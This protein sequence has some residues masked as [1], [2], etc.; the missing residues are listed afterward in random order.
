MS[1]ITSG[2]GIFSG[3]NRD[4]LI[5]QLLALDARPKAIFQRRIIQLQSISA[6]YLD[7]N[8]RLSSLRTAA[9]AFNVNK[10]FSA[11]TASSSNPDVATATA[12][13]NAAVGSYPFQFDR[14]V[15]TQ[16]V[17]STGF[18]DAT[19][20][21]AGLTSLTFAPTQARL[22]RD[23][24][25]STLNGG[26]GIVRGRIQITDTTGATATVDLSRAVSVS[27]VINTINSASGVN[28]RAR[29][30]GDRFVVTDQ[31]GGAGA[32][33]IGEVQG[34]STAASLGLLGSSP[35]GSGATIT[36]NQV[37]RVGAATTLSAL[38][39][40]LGVAISTAGGT[41]TPD[42][43][44]RTRDGQVFEIDLGELFDPPPP[45]A[46]PGSPNVRR[47]SA[48]TDLEGVMRRI[49][50]QTSTDQ[51]PDGAVS[52]SI[53]PGGVGLRLVDLTTPNGSDDFV[54]ENIDGRSTATDLGIAGTAS[55]NTIDGRRLVASMNST[56]LR[57][58][59]G[60]QGFSA[61]VLKVTLRNG[62]N[63]D[64]TL[65]GVQ[66]MS[67]L[68][69]AFN[70]QA[71]GQAR[72]DLDASGTRLVLSDLTGGTGTLSI[73]GDAA[74]PLGL[75]VSADAD[76][77]TSDR[78]RLQF[79]GESTRLET[80][81]Q[82][83]GVGTGRLEFSNAQG[84]RSTVN[85]GASVLTVGDLIGEI[86]R[87]AQ[88]VR[89][90]INDAGDGILLEEIVNPGDDPGGAAISVRDLSGSIARTLN[91][92]TTAPGTGSANTINGSLVRTVTFNS[93]DSLQ[94]VVNTLNNAGLPVS[95]AVINDGGAS[96]RPFR[97]SMTSRTSGLAGAFSLDAT[98]QP[99][100]FNTLTQAQDARVFFGAGDPANAVLLTSS[101]NTVTDA[102]SGLT[103]TAK[104]ASA[105]PV[106]ITVSRDNEAVTRGVQA[107][108]D[109]FNQLISRIDTLTS[110]DAQSQ[111][112][113]T[114]LGDS[115]AL[116]LRSQLFQ[117]VTSPPTGVD[118]RFQSLTQ[119]GITVGRNGQLSLDATRLASAIQEDAQ[120]VADLFAAKSQDP[121]A[122]S[123]PVIGPGGAPIPGVTVRT[124]S[125]GTFTRLGVMERFAD[126]AD[127]FIRP[128]D[129]R[130]TRASSSIDTQVKAQNERISALDARLASR[131]TVL[132]RQF[133][134]MEEAIG[135]LQGQSSAIGNIRP[136]TIQQRT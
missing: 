21:A 40:G 32:I 65:S 2:V 86:N 76:R 19:S 73:A 93:G 78:L 84:V 64:A 136:L 116:E 100:T 52:V 70:A 20:S 120:A 7:L 18:A 23:Q 43:R 58:I 39:D 28:V 54:V 115:N 60:G 25:L 1:G 103:V 10:I 9:Q 80:L 72:L 108:V 111:R 89:A 99:V 81:N 3:I 35:S 130:L 90:R 36:G 62:A 6:A 96:T 71:G 27:D 106:T 33:T 61:D 88:G 131:R 26:L 82:G 13:P 94:T 85:I 11:S 24:N 135:R 97:L 118:G 66:S 46:P 42:F 15:S 95:A 48:V 101:S 17:I 50:E 63:L 67:D 79:V 30:D 127:R 125:A 16:Q 129:G 98:G 37:N 51:F 110:F 29:I 121:P 56:L 77:V 74:E 55:G 87:Q 38:N 132:Q 133:L 83:R 5:D 22:D 69:A 53:G 44:I 75:L 91:L 119:V 41:S 112:R 122:T 8:T 14:L 57:N 113:G 134:A 123:E 59:N 47:E 104:A 107:F 124:T 114:L 49:R 45:D 128:V 109:T 34:G 92:N 4:Q 12:G 126:L 117:L 31:A 102:V 105:N 68:V